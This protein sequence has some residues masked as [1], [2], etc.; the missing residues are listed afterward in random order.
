MA[1]NNNLLDAAA[2]TWS[3]NAS[4]IRPNDDVGNSVYDPELMDR[5]SMNGTSGRYLATTVDDLEEHLQQDLAVMEVTDRLRQKR[6]LAIQRYTSAFVAVAFLLMVGIGNTSR[7]I[8]KEK[9]INRIAEQHRGNSG[10]TVLPPPPASLASKCTI[11]ALQTPTG[12]QECE[13]ACEIA[14]CCIVPAGF[15]LSCQLGNEVTCPKYR[16]YCDVL[17]WNTPIT[18]KDQTTDVVPAV[19]SGPPAVAPV[20]QPPIPVPTQAPQALVQPPVPSP[21]TTITPGGDSTNFPAE[22]TSGTN[23]LKKQIS[24]ACEENGFEPISLPGQLSVCEQFCQNSQCCF[25]HYCVP[26]EGIDCLD[27]SPCYVLYNE[28]DM[29]NT[30]NANTDATSANS[31][32]SNSTTK[33]NQS[34]EL[35]LQIQQA[36]DSNAV[37]PTRSLCPKLC[38][39]GAC[40]FEPQLACSAVNCDLYAAC[41][42]ALYSNY[43]DAI[44]SSGSNSAMPGTHT[45]EGE[46]VDACNNHSNSNGASSSLCEQ[47]CQEGACCFQGNSLSAQCSKA[48]CRTYSACQVVFG[49]A[50]P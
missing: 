47:I 26:P 21:T 8:E 11:S 24:D 31:A 32:A 39:V 9:K 4:G 45:S 7:T 35:A 49:S 15:A 42:D 44:S 48:F 19:S 40:C 12:T 10:F 30:D 27:Y 6:R 25:N 43:V 29:G 33:T 41:H 2:S 13:S 38:A 20:L 5:I 37:E 14:E 28:E 23:P 1:A 50:T 46:V 16:Q 18:S 22:D 17:D 3:G 34:N 36:C